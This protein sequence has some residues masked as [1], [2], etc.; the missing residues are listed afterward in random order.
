MNEKRQSG[1]FLVEQKR[2][3]KARSKSSLVVDV[4]QL[5]VFYYYYKWNDSYSKLNDELETKQ[6]LQFSGNAGL[7]VYQIY[8]L[9]MLVKLIWNERLLHTQYSKTKMKPIAAFL[10][11]NSM[12]QRWKMV[13]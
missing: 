7:R 6:S 13:G 4:R 11:L 2:P 12:Q 8:N 1:Y 5:L 10:N 9:H 3:Q